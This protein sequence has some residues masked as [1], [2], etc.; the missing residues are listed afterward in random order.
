M[1]PQ[2]ESGFLNAGTYCSKNPKKMGLKVKLS[3][4]IQAFGSLE[5]FCN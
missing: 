3:L 1:R 5:V 2:I 4:V